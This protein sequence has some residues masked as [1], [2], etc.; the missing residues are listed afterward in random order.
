MPGLETGGIL[1]GHEIDAATVKITRVSP[2]G[3]GAVHR[4]YFFNRDTPFLQRYLD[5]VHDR[6]SGREDYVGEWHVHPSLE[7]PPSYVDRR[8]LFR[9]ARRSNYA[10]SNPVLLIVEE[11]PG[12]RRLRLYGFAV[13]PRRSWCELTLLPPSTSE[14]E[15]RGKGLD[16]S[17]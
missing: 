6:S 2:P 11:A 4:R 12:E 3:P 10:P 13:T 5:D 16:R 17:G 7:A 9:I 1:I 15:T 14:D 8:A